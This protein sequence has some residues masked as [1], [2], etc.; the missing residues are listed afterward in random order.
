MAFLAWYRRGHRDLPW[1]RSP[2]PDPYRIW[3][4]GDRASSRPRAQA[5]I[6]GTTRTV[7][8]AVSLNR[9]RWPPSPEKRC[10]RALWSGLGY[11]SRARNLRAPS[12]ATA[13][14]RRFP[15]DLRRCLRARPG[16]A[17]TPRRRSKHR[18]RPAPTR[19]CSMRQRAAGGRAV[20][21]E[22]D[23]VRI[24]LRRRTRRALSRDRAIRGLTRAMPEASAPEPSS[25]GRVRPGAD[26][27]RAPPC[28]PKNP[29]VPAP[30]P[31]AAPC[32][33]SGRLGTAAQPPVKLRKTAPVKV[34][35]V[36]AGGAPRAADPAPAA[37]TPDAR[38]MCGL[39]GP[40]RAPHDLPQA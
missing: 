25:A 20:S 2:D 27:A 34:A 11:Y 21:A 17:I 36:L 26:G 32:R 22:N 35:G 28:L 12:R 16:S 8:R 38:R 39:L 14:G 23:A 18:L 29:H 40:A 4:V 24:S 33:A 10:A 9:R 19:W 13:G 15:A 30:V 5:V 7:S 3:V 1:R 37:A 6:P 31:L